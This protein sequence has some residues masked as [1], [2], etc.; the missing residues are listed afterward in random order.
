MMMMIKYATTH[1]VEQPPVKKPSADRQQGRRRDRYSAK[2][3]IQVL[4]LSTLKR[5]AALRYGSGLPNN[6]DG[7]AHIKAMLAAGLPAPDVS[8]WATWLTEVER[9]HMIA[10]VDS[11]Q[12]LSS[13]LGNL[14]ELTD[15]ERETWKLW[16]IRPFDVPLHVVKERQ[17]RKRLARNRER[18]RARR[19]RLD[20]A[21]DLDAREE[22][23]IVLLNNRWVAAGS[24]TACLSG[25]RAWQGLADVGRFIR[26]TL[27]RLAKMGLVENNYRKGRHGHERYVRKAEKRPGHPVTPSHARSARKTAI[28]SVEKSVSL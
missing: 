18:Q 7:R 9:E 8:I 15:H 1:A 13:Y 11:R 17:H 19:A 25:G 21:R 14:V 4:Q 24:L 2:I 26:R 20:I 5:L 10:E 3:T 28:S 16:H 12:W 22:S 6:R 27:D 23:V